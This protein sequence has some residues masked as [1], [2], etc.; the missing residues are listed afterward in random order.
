[1]VVLLFCAGTRSIINLK[2]IFTDP[3]KNTWLFWHFKTY[4][5]LSFLFHYFRISLVS[6]RG[7]TI[8]F[9][10]LYRFPIEPKRYSVISLSL[11]THNSP[12]LKEISL[13]FT[14]PTRILLFINTGSLLSSFVSQ[15]AI[16]PF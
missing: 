3:E 14:D 5:K 9:N 12:V 1:M 11:K 4:L 10:L 2:L 15:T 8:L 16:R 13:A 7:Y 6:I